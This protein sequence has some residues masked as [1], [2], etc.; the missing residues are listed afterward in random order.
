MKSFSVSNEKT[1]ITDIRRRFVEK[2]EKPGKKSVKVKKSY[3]LRRATVLKEHAESVETTD[4]RRL[5][6]RRKR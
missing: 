5:I 6:A 4:I 3:F 2:E 1:K